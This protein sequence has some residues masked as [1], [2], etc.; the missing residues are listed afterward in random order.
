MH[1]YWGFGLLISSEIEF[2][3]FLP[4]AFTEAPDLTI[5]LGAVPAELTAEGVVKKVKVSITATEY[6]QKLPVATYYVA[7]GNQII[8]EPKPDADEKSIRLFLLSN[9]MAAVLH[10]RNS[11]PLHASAVMLDEG[12]AIFCGPSGAG[13]STTATML[14]QKG[15][16][17]FSDDVC[18][19]KVDGD[20]V[21]AVPSYPMIK[22]W[23]DTFH[24]AG[25]DMA[26]EEEKI[27]PQ[28]P[29]FARFYHDEFDILPKTVKYI[30]LL[31]SN[32][33]IDEVSI[34]PLASIAAFAQ[35]QRNTYRP[36]QMNA[37]Q[38]RNQHFAAITRLTNAAPIYRISRPLGENTLTRV[39]ELIT[40]VLQPNE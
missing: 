36:V 4:F 8:V 35:L 40:N 22:L 10:Q 9:A 31:D 29:K 2:P 32:N 39:I 19:L 5:N 33:T 16:K 15:Y 7:N 11:I 12:I 6:L 1:Q 17:V 28:L 21:T 26:T 13:K 30:F 24:K 25:L 3:E 37:M 34:K 23:A 38:K 27:R 20:Q 18:V 14:Q